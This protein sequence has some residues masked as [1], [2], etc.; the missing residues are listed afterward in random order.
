MNRP[1]S[2][3]ALVPLIE[4]RLSDQRDAGHLLVFLPGLAE[5]RRVAK[6]LEPAAG[7]AGA[8]VLPLH[9]SLSAEDQDRALR[10]SDRRKIILSTNIAETSLTID[11]VTTV[12]DSGLARIVRYDAER[13]I[14]RWELGRISRAAAD[15]RAGRAGRTG[16]GAASASGPSATSAAVPSS[17]SPRSTASTSA[18]PCSPCTPGALPIPA[19]FDWYD[20]PSPGATGRRRTAAR[21][22]GRLAGDPPR[23]TPLGEEMLE[24][25]VH[26]RLARLLVAARQ[27]GRAREGAAHRRPAFGKRHPASRRLATSSGADR[28][29]A[30]RR[31]RSAP[32]S[33]TVSTCWP[34]PRRPGS[35]R[36]CGLAASIPPPR[37][38]SH[39]S[40]TSCSGRDRRRTDRR[41]SEP[42][43]E[44][45]DEDMLKW[46]L[47]AYP[48]RVVKRRGAE[49]TGV[50]VGGRGVRLGPESVVRDAELYLALDAREDRRAGSL[51]VQV[52]L[53]SMVRLEWLE[54][55]FP[56]LRAARATDSL[57]RVATAGHQHEPALVSRPAASRGRRSVR[58]PGRSRARA[59]RGPAAPGGQLVPRQ[60]PGRPL[61]R[62]FD[63]VRQA[64]PELNWPD[65]NDDCPRRIARGWSAREKRASTRSNRPISIPF[66][67]SRLDPAQIRELQES[68]RSRSRSPADARSAWL[69]SRDGRR[70]WRPGSR[71]CSAGPKHRA[72][73]AAAFPSCC[74]CWARTIGR[75]RSPTTC[76]ASGRP[77][78][79][80]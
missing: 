53:A 57:R 21:P 55:L 30:D 4:E 75:S 11:G 10:P 37:A 1:A 16:P 71:S 62:R 31:G 3:E 70:S 56:G 76:A 26:P 54:E 19:R 47:L 32:T 39:C 66:L 27:V 29:R 64:L 15:Q 61:A 60:S 20:P 48:D 40:A 79:T 69:M 5:I 74:T 8:L 44:A 73:R 36:R 51:E 9:G 6:R 59:G 22:A 17:S 35:R 46:L 7:R 77:P 58:R 68:A 65:F 13:G 24:L 23:I 14:D 49:R 12:I 78:I 45:D 72:L 34:R 28:A 18:S 67:Q 41:P 63:F 80:R 42:A 38:R 2:A 25:P 43:I 50:M 52:S 33:S